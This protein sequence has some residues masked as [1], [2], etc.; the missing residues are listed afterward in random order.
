MVPGVVSSFEHPFGAMA[1]NSGVFTIFVVVFTVAVCK[2]A[3]KAMDTVVVVVSL[4]PR[5]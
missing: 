4:K 3:V 1:S 5:G 2:V